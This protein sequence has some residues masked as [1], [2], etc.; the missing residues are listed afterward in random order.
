MTVCSSF[1]PSFFLHKRQSEYPEENTPPLPPSPP[2]DLHLSEFLISPPSHWFPAVCHHHHI[3]QPCKYL[4]RHGKVSP[5]VRREAADSSI[6]YALVYVPF[7][8]VPAR[9]YS[10]SGKVG[11]AKDSPVHPLERKHPHWPQDDL[12]DPDG[13]LQPSQGMFPLPCTLILKN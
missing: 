13:S 10:G 11:P 9:G 1:P 8:S 2:S 7:A 4:I 5:K 6:T 3:H 12:M